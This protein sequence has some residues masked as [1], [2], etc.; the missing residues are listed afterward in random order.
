[1]SEPFHDLRPDE[2]Y[3]QYVAR[4][5][6]VG[7]LIEGVVRTSM[8]ARDIDPRVKSNRD[9]KVFDSWTIRYAVAMAVNL[10]LDPNPELVDVM[11]RLVVEKEIAP[12]GAIE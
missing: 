4:I 2:T 10:A 5:Q 12:P 11:K 1:M 9:L 8:C 3:E 7:D 6:Y